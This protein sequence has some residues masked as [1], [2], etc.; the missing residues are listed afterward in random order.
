MH[1]SLDYVIQ[2]YKLNFEALNTIEIE[3]EN[4]IMHLYSHINEK[5]NGIILLGTGGN[6]IK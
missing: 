2:C 3:S 5:N 1:L 6:S 4:E